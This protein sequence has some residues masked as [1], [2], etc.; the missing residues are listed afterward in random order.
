M[1]LASTLAA[2]LMA[3][4]LTVAA[5]LARDQRRMESRQARAHS[6]ALFDLLRRDLA[7]GAALIPSTTPNS[8][9]L[10][11]HAGVD[12]STLAPAQRLVLI[13]YHV[14]ARSAD[15]LLREQ[16][17]LDDPIRPQPCREFVAIG[18]TRLSLVPVSADAE[19]V[20][21]GDEVGERLRAADG[22]AET[23]A[24]TRVPSR[25][26]VRVDF[27]DGALQRELVLR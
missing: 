16:R 24:A 15:A 4:V 7:N 14:D 8:I 3:A 23:P 25:L 22:R 13:R 18:V 21:L 10:I 11:G 1:L 27:A 2:I 12:P 19:I 20:R 5:A 17:F 6:P 9:E 26:V